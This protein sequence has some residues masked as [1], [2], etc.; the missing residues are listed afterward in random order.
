MKSPEFLE[1][2]VF[3][4]LVNS[5]MR[6]GA[7]ERRSAVEHDEKDDTGSKD[8]A[9]N[10]GVITGLHFWRFVSFRSH[11]RSEPEV[12]IVALGIPREAEVRNFEAE[13]AVE[14]NVLRFQIPMRHADLC[15]VFDR[16]Y[17]LFGIGAADFGKELSLLGQEI[18]ELSSLGQFQDNQ[19]TLFFRTGTNFDFGVKTVVN[20]VDQVRKVEFGKKFGF[21]F[22]S[23]FPAGA[24]KIDLEGVEGVVLAA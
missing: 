8:V 1:V 2:L 12:S 15:Q 13:V 7:Q 6:F 24:G 20:H 23:F 18:K 16:R 21:E 9:L 17:E 10:S 22:E 5:I 19:W 3:D 14:E 11:S 4:E